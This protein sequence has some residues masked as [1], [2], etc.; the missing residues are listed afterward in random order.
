MVKPSIARGEDQHPEDVTRKCK[1]IT[2]PFIGQNQPFQTLVIRISRG[3]K[4]I[5]RCNINKRWYHVIDTVVSG[6][7]VRN[8][9]Y[10]EA[11]TALNYSQKKYFFFTFFFV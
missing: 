8:V 4:P 2:I 11:E 6:N 9:L 1:V 10:S 7:L 5:R 3:S